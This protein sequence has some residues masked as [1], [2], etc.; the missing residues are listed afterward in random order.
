MLATTKDHAHRIYL[1]RGIY[2]E[3]TLK[4]QD[5]RWRPWPWTYPD[6]ADGR[7]FEFFNEVR[8]SLHRQRQE[9]GL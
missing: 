8:Q 6:Y 2:A 9:M 5:G 7:Y 4:F 1:A 3:I